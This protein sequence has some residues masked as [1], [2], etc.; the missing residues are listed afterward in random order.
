MEDLGK[1][2]AAGAVQEVD[3]RLG[4][5]LLEGEMGGGGVAVGGGLWLGELYTQPSNFFTLLLYQLLPGIQTPP[6]KLHLP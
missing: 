1:G 4:E 5:G 6:H 3:G 2:L